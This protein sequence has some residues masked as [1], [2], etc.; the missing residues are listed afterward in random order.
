M[1]LARERLYL[2]ADRDRL[3][4]TGDPKAAFLY[5]SPGDEIPDSA[6]ARFGLAD[7]RLKPGKRNT[8][9]TLLGSSVLPA[10][11]EIAP[12]KS[13]Q[14]G[15]VVVQARKASG[16]SVDDW[17]A[18]AEADREARLAQEV[19]VLKA[20]AAMSPKPVKVK[21]KVASARKPKAAKEKPAPEDKEKRVGED[22]SGGSQQTE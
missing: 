2:T 17:N 11:I 20:E 14:L 6:A 12:G 10:E 3:V 9:D 18:L 22:K 4:R 15:R 16:L 13:V 21:V 8:G 5:A 19:E 7:G 1:M